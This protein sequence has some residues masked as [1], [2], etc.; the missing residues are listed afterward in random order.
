MTHAQH[1]G[2]VSFW[3]ADIGGLPAPRSPLPGDRKVD[4]VIVGAGYTGLWTAYYLKKESPSLR[5]AVIEREFAGFGAS[6]RNGG[7]LSGGFSW[8]REKYLKTSTRQRVV[9]MQRAMAG[10][11]GDVI[12]VAEEEGIDADIL[13]VDNLRVA[14]NAAQ[15]ERLRA[16]FQTIR[17][18]DFN[19]SRLRWLDQVETRR[20]IAVNNALGG[21][22][23]SGQARVQPAKLVR[24]L[25]EVVERLGVPIY[26]QTA[27]TAIEKGKVSTERGDVRAETIVR[28]TEGFTAGIPGERRTWLPLNSAQIVTEP[29]P[30]ELW[31]EIGWEGHELLGDAAHAYCYA[32]RTREG[33]ITM[34]GRGVPYRFGSRTDV[35]GRT[36]QATIDQLH[37]ILRKLLPQ[38]AG[39]RIDHAWCGVLGVPRD[40]CTTVGLDPEKRI[41]WAGGYVG[42]GVS[43]SNL[44]GRTLTDLILGRQ[45][46]LVEL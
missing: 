28:A 2:D 18:W 44:S 15:L 16:D 19:P 37:T 10:T 17:D 6:G 31:T 33:R 14:T 11:V 9:D 36:Q 25:A 8:S 29:V 40:W 3:Y 27:V 46:D 30:D 45:S 1:N 34:G 41:A 12:R 7:W 26:E 20:R 42:L 23:V 21:Y 13:R 32:Q 43:S 35:K 22:V 39:L 5:I 24:G 4:V 38:A